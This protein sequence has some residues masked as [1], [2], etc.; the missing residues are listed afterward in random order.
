MS[1]NIGMSNIR[2]KYLKEDIACYEE[3]VSQQ[4]C[5]KLVKYYQQKQDWTRVAFYESYGMNMLEND[6]QLEDFGLPSNYLA[7]IANRMQSAVEQ[8]LSVKVKR[9]ST[10][11]QKWE[12]GAF[13]SFHSDNSNMDGTP[14]AWER[15]KYVCLLY[16]NQDYE[17]GELNFRDYPIT[18][19]PPTGMLVAFPGG[20]ENI[21]EVKTVTSG[22]RYTLGAFWDNESSEYSKEQWDRWEKEIEAVREIQAKQYAE[23]DKEN[24]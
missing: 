20:F 24:N 1:Y 23:W 12:T 11:A 9:V 5:E 19:A 16:L 13:A 22:T 15:S 14:S 17:G 7:D 8:A 18:I 21:H 6:I 2:L 4:D 3:F 10:H